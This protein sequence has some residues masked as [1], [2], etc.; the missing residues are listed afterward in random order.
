MESQTII[1]NLKIN[2]N[3]NI[4]EVVV[5][6]VEGLDEF[7]LLKHIFTKV[8]N[9]SYIAI[10]R[11]KVMKDIFLS[12][13]SKST[14]IIINTENSNIN[15]VLKDKNYKDN[16][17]NLLKVDF[18]RSLKNVPIYILWD[19]DFGSNDIN[20]VKETLNVF[21][22]ALD[23]D[24]EM[25]RLLLLSYPCFESYEL[26]NFDKQF[27]KTNIKTSRETKKLNKAKYPKLKDIN[28]D[29][30]LIA[31][32]NMHKTFKNYEI[33]K[34]DTAN[35]KET[36]L[37]IFNLEEKIFKKNDYYNALSL[38][39]LMLIDLGIIEIKE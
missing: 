5:I 29:T 32:L 8:L 6:V 2:K 36:N 26:S 16:L 15:S 21:G 35:F 27:W 19:R 33:L 39:S 4:G 12:S 24:Y 31:V 3:K 22:N 18:K 30:L 17:Y 38:I 1:K 13:N 37:K 14:V 25:N 28:K 11:K 34:Y 20:D 7:K 23:N 9:Y 10:R